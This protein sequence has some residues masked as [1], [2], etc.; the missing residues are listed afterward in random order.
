VRLMLLSIFICALAAQTPDS[1]VVFEVASIKPAPPPDGRGMIVRRDGGPGTKDP[2]RF[3]CKNWQLGGLVE[4]A[5]GIEDYQLSG[6]SW[7]EETRFDVEARVPEGATKEQFKLMMRNLLMERFKLATHTETRDVAGYELDV[8]KGGSKLTPSKGAEADEDE[9]SQRNRQPG[10]RKDAEGYPELPPG[11][12]SWMGVMNGRARG[13][14]VDESLAEFVMWVAGETRRP[15]KD[16]TGLNGKYDF[17]LTWSFTS[18]RADATDDSGP[19][20]EA[21]IQQQLG[22][23]LES[24]KI[25]IEMVIIDHIAKTPTGN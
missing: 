25:P 3:S 10:M 23:R 14:F 24:K 16:A 12:T 18:M 5:Y 17:V 20:L 15:V 8:A 6:P 4:L 7:L 13:R 11:R 9:T 22:F 21:A 1:R 2:T 19:T